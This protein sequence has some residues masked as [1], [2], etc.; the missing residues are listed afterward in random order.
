MN[1][2]LVKKFRKV[3]ALRTA[4][5]VTYMQHKVRGYVVVPRDTAQGVYRDIKR[6]RL[7]S[8]VLQS[9]NILGTQYV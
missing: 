2:K 9:N 7:T 5:E 3:L 8:A 4:P 6:A 1:A